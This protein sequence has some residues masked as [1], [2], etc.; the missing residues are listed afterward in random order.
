MSSLKLP[1]DV[2]K[3]FFSELSRSD[4]CVCQRPIGKKE[5]EAIMNNADSYLDSDMAGVL[6]SIKDSIETNSSSSINI[7]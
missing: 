3:Q 7:D 5:Q 1:G 4:T 2:A 6:N